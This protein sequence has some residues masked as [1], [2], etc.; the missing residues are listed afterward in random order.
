MASLIDS[1]T[2]GDRLLGSK[3]FLQSSPSARAQCQE[4]C[5]LYADHV[6]SDD[7]DLAEVMTATGAMVRASVRMMVANVH[8]LPLNGK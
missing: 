8:F 5:D 1:T 2:I 4:T 6:K 3:E 7:V